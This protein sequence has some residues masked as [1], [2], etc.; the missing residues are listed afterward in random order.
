MT[1]W[2]G[3]LRLMLSVPFAALGNALEVCSSALLT[4]AEVIGGIDD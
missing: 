2:I 1:R 3:L 4:L